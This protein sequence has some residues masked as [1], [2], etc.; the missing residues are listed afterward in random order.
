MHQ[1]IEATAPWPTR[2]NR[3]FDIF[4]FPL[5][6]NHFFPGQKSLTHCLKFLNAPTPRVNFIVNEY[7]CIKDIY[8]TCTLMAKKREGKCLG[9]CLSKYLH[10]PLSQKVVKKV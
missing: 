4:H 1:S 7:I 10:I 5:F 6:Y 3:A 8:P 9:K 2:N